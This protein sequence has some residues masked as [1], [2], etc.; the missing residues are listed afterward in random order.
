MAYKDEY[1]VARLLLVPEARDAAEAVGGK[2]ARITWQL[3]PPML[4]ALGMHKKLKL[5]AQTAPAFRIL[6]AGKRVRGTAL[7][8]FGRSAVRRLERSLIS[9]YLDV[10][11]RLE[12]R[13]TAANL[14]AAVAIAA[15]P[16][17]VRGYESLKERRAAEYRVTLAERLA[18]FEAR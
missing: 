1:E 7:D 9:E 12:R 14:D 15:L 6:A 17:H 8:P 4:R 5:R 3:H 18:A 2:G 13:L 11:D 16:D 10:L